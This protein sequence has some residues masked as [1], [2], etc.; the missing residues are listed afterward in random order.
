MSPFVQ[1]SRV[2][3]CDRA[4]GRGVLLLLL[5]LYTATFTGTP[6]NP[7]AEVEF[8]TT[9]SLVRRGRLDLGGTPEAEALLAAHP[10]GQPTRGFGVAPGGPGREERAYGWFGV[11]Q[12]FSGVPLYL[13]GAGLARLFPGVQE[14]H[15]AAPVEGFGRSEYFQHFAVGWRNA[16]LTAL[17][18]CLVVLAARRLGAGGRAA[19]AAGLAYGV[20]T[21]AWPQA[22]STLSDVQATFCLFLGFH[23]L[24]AA[25]ERW[26]RLRRPPLW[27]L[28]GAGAA[29]GFAVLTRV[30]LAPAAA[31]LA[32]VGV[33]AILSRTRGVRPGWPVAALGAFALP[34]ALAA[35]AFF[36]LNLLRFGDP[37]ETG[38]G[39][40][41]AGGGFFAERPWAGLAGLLVSPGRG[42]LWMAPGLLLVP[43]GVIHARRRGEGFLPWVVLGVALAV[44]APTAFL[45][46][47]HGAQT[48][49]PRYALPLLPFAWLLVAQGLD[50]CAA[51]VG[52]RLAALAVLWSGLLTSLP[53]V[54]VDTTTYHELAQAAARIAW[55][56][57]ETAGADATQQDDERFQR[58]LWDLRFAAPWA[59][60]RIL[61]R[62]VADQGEEHPVHEIFYLADDA[63]LSPGSDRRRG[64]RHLAWI[65]LHER[66]GAPL[67]PA[68]VVCL[69]LLVAGIGFA[70]R[71]LDD[72][73]L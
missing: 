13:A 1:P 56:A 6:E 2:R 22:R 42:L 46:G 31:F 51:H 40:G 47:W 39:V 68:V 63:V 73:A 43:L 5:A 15:A 32:A 33:L 10:P 4:L 9:S 49:G 44:L 29:I 45:H 67:W 27:R 59:H 3:P 23:L 54:L 17:T 41:I 66:L 8:Q 61:R 58:I 70:G 53:G 35:V 65:D 36:G 71:G 26:T 14:R 69:G 55:P 25:R 48:Y 60:W 28:A 12:A 50:R 34:L 21:F 52:R 20:A 62:R 38:Y 30:A 64:Q 11:G 16:L 18:G 19:F 7:D 72:P 57:D 24:L 37:L